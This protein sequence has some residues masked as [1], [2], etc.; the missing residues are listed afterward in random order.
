MSEEPAVMDQF[1]GI[2]VQDMKS[3]LKLEEE[4][5]VSEPQD[6]EFGVNEVPGSRFGMDW[7]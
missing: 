3:V 6:A 7:G 1:D 4:R 5:P 2:E